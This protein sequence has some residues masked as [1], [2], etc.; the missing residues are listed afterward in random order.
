MANTN[1]GQ[2]ISS[3]NATTH[4]GTSERLIV[5]GERQEDFDALL[6]NLLEEYSPET[7][8]ARQR[9]KNR[10]AQSRLA[11]VRATV[12]LH[13]LEQILAASAAA[14]PSPRCHRPAP[15]SLDG[16]PLEYY[17]FTDRPPPATPS[18]VRPNDFVS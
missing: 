12:A 13:R 14:R 16:I 15:S 8:D 4:G 11:A 1:T 6:H 3:R 17:S 7:P 5:A 2:E 18:P 9:A 10:S